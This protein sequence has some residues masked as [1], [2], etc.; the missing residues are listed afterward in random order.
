MNNLTS[1]IVTFISILISTSAAAQGGIEQYQRQITIGGKIPATILLVG[2]SKDRADI[3]KLFNIVSSKTN[4]IYANLD[5][6]NPS[7]DVGRINAKAGQGPVGVIPDTIV[8][9]ETAQKISKWSKGAF[10]IT[11]AGPGDWRDI[12]IGKDTVELKKADMQV[13]FEPMV[14]GFMAETVSRLIYASSMQNVMVKVGGVFR[15]IGQNT[16]GPWK[17]QIQD[18]EGTFARHALNLTV[19][20]TGVAAVSAGDYRVQRLIDPRSKKE[21]G[22]PSRGSVVVMNDAAEA[23]GISHAVFTMGP[24]DGMELITK[25]GKGLIVDN[26]GKFMRSPGF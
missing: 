18:D 23:D 15:G 22:T 24:K 9:F 19:T 13:R 4:E 5:W 6:Q 8:A 17:I 11:Y 25:L 2:Y 26:S 20:N 14:N 7:G 3:N 12:T 10:D 16:T 21:I 1:L